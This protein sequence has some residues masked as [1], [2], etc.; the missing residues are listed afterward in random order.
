MQDE[1]NTSACD[2]WMLPN[3]E[4]DGLWE[5]LVYEPGIKSSLLGFASAAMLFSS[6][7]VDP[8]EISW[9]R[10]VL[11]HGPPGTGKTSLCKALAHKLA[12]RLTNQFSTSQL[13][14]VNAHSLFSK[15][16][17]ESGKL[18]ARLFARIHSIAS[19]EDCMVFV[20][21]DEIESLTAARKAAVNGSEPSDALRVVNA[22]LTQLDNLKQLP[23]V[24]VLTTSNIT[25]AIDEA[26]LDRAD[27]KLYIG[28]P[29]GSA[30]YTILRSC[31]EELQRVGIVQNVKK[32]PIDIQSA[33]QNENGSG[34]VEIVR[35]SDGISGRMLRKLPFVTHAREF[36]GQKMNIPLNQFINSLLK[37]CVKELQSKASLNLS[38]SD[39]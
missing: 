12:V 30:R 10:V 15:W 14:E 39:D 37:S 26:F 19:N 7:G 8:V 1:E 24:M 13:L 27:I 22:L 20:L 29:S 4:Y 21:I 18:V 6:L 5:G 23:N 16:F 25:K 31:I 38:G 2:Q 36:G 33:A 17:S 3:M 11:L 9:N 28:P 34:L 32:L 35:K